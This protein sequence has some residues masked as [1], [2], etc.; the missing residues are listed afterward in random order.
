MF[1]QLP[2]LPD[3]VIGLKITDKITA[4]DYRA[5]LIPLV[6]EKLKKHTHLDCLCLLENQFPGVEPAALWEDVRLGLSNFNHWG[7]IAIVTDIDWIENSVNLFKIFWPGHLRQFDLND[8]NRAREWVSE[9]HRASVQ[10]EIDADDSLLIIKPSQDRSLS[11][12]DFDWITKIADDY[13]AEHPAINGILIRSRHFP[14]WQSLGAMMS[15]LKF[16]HNHH[17][18]IKRIAVVS[19]SPLGKFADHVGDHFVKAEI[20][21]FEYDQHQDALDWLKNYAADE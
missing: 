6:E 1:E 9:R 21:A 8:Y 19:N 3:H 10:V 14:G 11:I 20:K 4:Q 15:H 12:Y 13:L 7:R 16:V 18:K 5:I 17:R 2:D